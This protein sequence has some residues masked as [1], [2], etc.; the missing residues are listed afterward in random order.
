M[1][2]FN[3]VHDGLL[4]VIGIVDKPRS[5]TRHRTYGF[6]APSERCLAVSIS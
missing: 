4:L 3:P 2:N 6:S 5:F 1:K